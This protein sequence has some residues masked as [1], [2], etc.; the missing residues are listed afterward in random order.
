MI[1]LIALAALGAAMATP[2]FA[3]TT[4]HASYYGREFAGRRTASGERFNPNGLTAA[5]RTLPFG[6]QLRL[7]NLANGKST[8]VRI[9]DRGPFI[10][11][12]MLDV[13]HGAAR[14]LGFAGAGTA[15]LRME[16][17]D[18]RRPVT[19]SRADAG[20]RASGGAAVVDGALIRETFNGG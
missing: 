6:T 11:G 12:R 7:T 3:Q 4:G 2:V 14:V 10:R 13:S 9:N 5:H 19:E 8:V 15:R 17:L 1:R 20:S 16:A 18:R